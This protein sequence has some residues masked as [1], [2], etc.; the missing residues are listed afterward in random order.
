MNIIDCFLFLMCIFVKSEISIAFF[1]LMCY[2]Y[3]LR[4]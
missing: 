2:K 4:R 1:I 3:M